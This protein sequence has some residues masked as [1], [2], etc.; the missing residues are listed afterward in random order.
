MVAGFLNFRKL[1]CNQILMS[2]IQAF[3][4]SGARAETEQV[5]M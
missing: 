3:N 5:D 4:K 2:A 1:L